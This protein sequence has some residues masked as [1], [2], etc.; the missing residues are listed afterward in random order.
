MALKILCFLSLLAFC[1]AGVLPFFDPRI[2]NG[3]DA[4]PGE[5]P[6]Q[7]SLQQKY[8]SF[9]FCG[10]S[11]LNNYYVITAAHCVENQNARDIKVVAGTI[12]L[13]D[14]KSEHNVVKITVH[15]EYDPSNSYINDIALL[16]VDRSLERFE[17]VPLLP[18]GD[19]VKPN[20]IAVVSGWGRLWQGGPTTVK[21]QRVNILIGDQSYCKYMYNRI[22]YN[23]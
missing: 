23:I 1:H 9:H 11:V 15:K 12:N 17:H 3:E 8:S 18:K 22:G 19:V 6:Y 10:G 5:I 7:V 20:D 16:K 4:K 14:P 21:L 2:V 13:T